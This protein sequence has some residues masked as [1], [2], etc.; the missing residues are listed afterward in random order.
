MTSLPVPLIWGRVGENGS[1]VFL[2]EGV[3]AVT[4]GQAKGQRDLV[5]PFVR[6][7]RQ[8]VAEDSVYALFH[9][10]ARSSPSRRGSSP[11]CSPTRA[12]V[13]AAIDRGARHGV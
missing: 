4:W 9:P 10:R 1:A 7:C 12:L 3:M 5:D 2:A 11:I 6:F 8:A 13:G